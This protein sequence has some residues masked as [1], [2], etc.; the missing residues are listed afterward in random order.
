MNIFIVYAHPSKKS[1]TYKILNEII[2]KL[3]CANCN[4]ELS[5]LYAM[6]FCS[7]MSEEEYER[8][9][10]A[11]T[12]ISLTSDVI[13]EQRKI[14]GQILLYFCTLFGGAIAPQS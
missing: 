11:K 13:K 7:D 6:N 3:R 9:G 12:E 5:D 4:I 8:E 2:N 10:F 14:A 1:Y